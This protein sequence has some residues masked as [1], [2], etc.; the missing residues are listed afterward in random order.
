MEKAS[1]GPQARTESKGAPDGFATKIDAA[2]TL[3]ELNA[4]WEE[5]VKGGFSEEIRSLF[6]SRKKALND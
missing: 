5:A 3:I 4:L 1:R 6:T 2:T